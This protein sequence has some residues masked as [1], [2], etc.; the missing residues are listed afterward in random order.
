MNVREY[1][2]FRDGILEDSKDENGFVSESN[3]LD[4]ILPLMLE[5]KLVDSEDY[6][7][8]YFVYETENIKLNGY[9]VNESG[10]RLQLFIVDE[11]TSK[12]IVSVDELMISNNEN[13]NYQF[14]RV[15][16][17]IMEIFK[18]QMGIQ[19]QDADPIKTLIAKMR[20]SEGVEQFDV[21]EIFLISFTVP[22]TTLGPNSQPR[23]INYKEEKMKVSFTIG[24]ICKTKEII[25]LKSLVDLNYIF[26][27]QNTKGNRELLIINF[28]ATFHYPIEVIK[29]ADEKNFASYLCYLPAQIISELYKRYSSR[30]LEKNVRSFLQFKG[31]NK[32]IKE[33]I[34][35]EPEKFIAYNNGLTI[36][37]VSAKMKIKKG[38][39]YIHE[40]TDFQI[41]NGGQTTAS[42]YFSQKEG[43]DIENV[44]VVAKINIAKETPEKDL[45][46]LI[47]NISNYS[48]A[49]SRVSS[50]DLKSRNPKLVKLKTLSE[51]VST[52][53]G[54]KWY[55]ERAKGEFNTKVRNSG[56][57]EHRVKID[58]PIER[59]FTKEQLAKY[60]SAWDDK[61]YM[62]KKGGEKV[63]RYFIEKMSDNTSPELEINKIFYEELISKIVLFRSLEKKYG[64]GD[65]AIGQ[66]RSAVIPYTISILYK[67]T[68]GGGKGV[69]FDLLKIWQHQG[70]E[71]DISEY[72]KD[73][74]FLINNLI[75][76]YS[77]SDDYGEYSK[78]P[79][80]WE[81]IITSKEIKDFMATKN[82]SKIF[83]KYTI[84]QLEWEKCKKNEA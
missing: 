37:S 5:A 52:P 20:S 25:I 43:L 62:V 50:V 33:T 81:R 8:T 18:E 71:N 29:A 39:M 67:Y 76:K 49:Q 28:D 79:E 12:S 38:K 14:K 72:L 6:T 64:Q 30:L 45:D 23:R 19:I 84:S 77:G 15:S 51:S 47:S 36:T 80:L 46:E 42:I 9:A 11:S 61:P 58:F 75:K 68:D 1:M 63:F 44:R 26:D 34:R 83:K 10:E 2:D 27:M 66:I 82:S 54:V 55:F 35:K 7:Y 40:L 60:Y 13:Y 48:N 56:S 24:S 57:K 17:L 41:V 69:K 65:I 78:K 73:L 16:K 4:Q 3:I 74:M 70:L 53:T 32:G 59:R 22:V 31:V 21:I